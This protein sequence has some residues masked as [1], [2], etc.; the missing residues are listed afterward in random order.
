LPGSA[1]PAFPERLLTLDFLFPTGGGRRET[2]FLGSPILG[3]WI[4]GP[5][6]MAFGAGIAWGLLAAAF[7]YLHVVAGIRRQL[8]SRKPLPLALALVGSLIRF[9]FLFA[10][11]LVAAYW[12]R[13][14]LDAAVVSF[15]VSHLAAMLL[16]GNQLSADRWTPKN[17]NDEPD[18]RGGLD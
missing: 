18:S 17:D 14:R 3:K 7:Q 11:F 9:G 10:F 8:R 4:P 2:A 15:A 16:L 1:F 13:V 5:M 6:D 12:D